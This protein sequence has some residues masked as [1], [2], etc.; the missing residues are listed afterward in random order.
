MSKRWVDKGIRELVA[1][2]LVLDQLYEQATAEEREA[3]KDAVRSMNHDIVS[4]DRWRGL[5]P[6]RTK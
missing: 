3:I 6:V 5:R 1:S 2:A 4:V